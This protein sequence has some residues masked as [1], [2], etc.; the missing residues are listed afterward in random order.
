MGVKAY[1]RLLVLLCVLAILLSSLSSCTGIL[2]FSNVLLG[3][4]APAADL[5]VSEKLAYTLTEA[6]RQS[7]L[8]ALEA[9]ESLILVKRSASG[10][11]ITAACEKMENA[12]YHVATQTELAYIYHCLNMADS[13]KSEAYLYAS[14]MQS[15]LYAAYEAACKRIDASDAPGRSVFFADWSEEDLEAMRGYST[16][17]NAIK[18]Q[19]ER[20]LVTYRSLSKSESYDRAPELYLQIVENNNRIAALY[21][22]QNYSDYA[23]AKVYERDYTPEDAETIHQSVKSI[24]VPLCQTALAKFQEGYA[25]L[26]SGER[27]VVR[28]LLEGEY[29]NAWGLFEEYFASFPKEAANKMTSLFQSGNLF[30]TS[31]EN[32]D[33]GAFTTYLYEYDQPVC[34]FGPGYHDGFTVIHELGHYISAFYTEGDLPMDIAETQSQANEWLFTAYLDQMLQ[35][36]ALAQTVFYYQLHS[37]LQSIVISSIIDEFEQSVYRDV[38]A[39]AEELDQRMEEV[40][41]GYGGLVSVKSLFADPMRYWRAVVLESPCYYISYAFSMLAAMNFYQIAT[42][43]YSAAQSAYLELVALDLKRGESYCDWL[44]EQNLQTPF[45]ESYYR[46]IAAFV[47]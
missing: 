25:A 37:A 16:E 36:R 10:R 7:F 45:E 32:A 12:Y 22:Y 19:N 5:P 29:G 9:V 11:E 41:R 42:D 46:E 26:G 47:S 23:Y 18:Q 44:K 38:P 31:A 40:C 39:S 8:E 34:Y 28:A 2:L 33:P 21:G 35:S 17:Y 15:D 3:Q 30:L 14:E 24:L 20:L 4:N 1:K 13:E 27:S 43:S 6:D